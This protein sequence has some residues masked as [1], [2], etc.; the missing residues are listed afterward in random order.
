MATQSAHGLLVGVLRRYEA[1]AQQGDAHQRPNRYSGF[2]HIRRKERQIHL[3]LLRPAA[4]FFK[5][6]MAARNRCRS[7][8]SST[9]QHAL[10][11]RL[12][13]PPRPT[14]SAEGLLPARCGR[15]RA[16]H[17]PAV[18]P[19]INAELSN[20]CCGSKPGLTLQSF[21]IVA[22]HQ[23]EADV[24]SGPQGP[25]RFARQPAPEARSATAASVAAV[26]FLERVVQVGRRGAAQCRCEPDRHRTLACRALTSAR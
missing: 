7:W 18:D 16:R 13:A 21:H 4:A 20:T 1:T 9:E 22:D 23:P 2:D 14:E 26:A 17:G 11:R 19:A 3:T 6:S 15:R 10:R 5:S 25:A 24:P 12:Q 8:L